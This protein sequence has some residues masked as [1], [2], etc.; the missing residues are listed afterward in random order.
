MKPEILILI[1]KWALSSLHPDVMVQLSPVVGGPRPTISP[2]FFRTLLVLTH[3][4]HL[5]RSIVLDKLDLWDRIDVSNTALARHCLDLCKPTHPLHIRGAL[6]S[7]PVPQSLHDTLKARLPDV[8]SISIQETTVLNYIPLLLAALDTPGSCVNLEFLCL[9]G[10]Y[11]PSL[12]HIITSYAQF[13]ALR[14]LLICGVSLRLAA[15]DDTPVSIPAL[16]LLETLSIIMP[17]S[18]DLIPS[19]ILPLLARCSILKALHIAITLRQ[20]QLRNDDVG[21]EPIQYTGTNLIRNAL[22]TVTSLSLS[23]DHWQTQ[24]ALTTFL[25]SHMTNSPITALF[26]PNIHHLLKLLQVD[27]ESCL[28]VSGFLAC[29]CKLLLDV[30]KPIHEVYQRLWLGPEK[31]GECCCP[32]FYAA[33]PRDFQSVAN[34]VLDFGRISKFLTTRITSFAFSI[35]DLMWGPTGDSRRRYK[36]DEKRWAAFFTCIPNVTLMSIVDIDSRNPAIPKFVI[37]LLSALKNR[38]RLATPLTR[39]HTS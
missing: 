7:N 34:F 2:T 30:S 5:W 9:R 26:V 12:T 16:P 4:C 19:L 33:Y 23:C 24:S 18:K 6:A 25:Y 22:R 31:R 28:A 1:C 13:T 36:P 37:G 10:P 38:T 27:T 20:D 29:G 11:G 32:A 39:L 8:R 21:S 15:I 17:F 3:T 35:R 14:T